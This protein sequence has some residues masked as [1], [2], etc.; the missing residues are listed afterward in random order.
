MRPY[1]SLC[2]EWDT[3]KTLQAKLTDAAGRFDVIV[4]HNEPS[5]LASM[6][7]QACP[8]DTIVLDA[9]D[10]NLC[11]HDRLDAEECEAMLDIEGLKVVA[12]G[13]F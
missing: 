12:R 11:R 6:A 1:L 8:Q 4:C 3:P 9:H 7:R 10:L 5:W 2:S 13:K